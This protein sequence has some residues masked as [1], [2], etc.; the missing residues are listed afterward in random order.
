[1]SRLVPMP[2]TTAHVA[3]TAAA[4]AA[5]AAFCPAAPDAG[6]L[7]RPGKQLTQMSQDP[8]WQGP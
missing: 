5:A 6:L 7:M 4:A 2:A 8:C 1:M 3:I